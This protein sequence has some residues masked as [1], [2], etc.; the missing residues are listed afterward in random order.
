M[1]LHL[2]DLSV[3]LRFSCAAQAKEHEKFRASR[4]EDEVGAVD[5]NG[6]V[7]EEGSVRPFAFACRAAYQLDDDTPGWLEAIREKHYGGAKEDKNKSVAGRV[8]GVGEEE[9]ESKEERRKRE[10][11]ERVMPLAV[12]GLPTIEPL[13]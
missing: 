3:R 4:K 9:E 10:E 8:E 12:K 11:H 13:D 1:Y 6:G 5:E 7:E 2:G